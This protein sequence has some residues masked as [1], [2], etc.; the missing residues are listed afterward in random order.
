MTNGAHPIR[1]RPDIDGLRALAVVA[2]VLFHAGVPG[3]R[4]GF[5][6]VDVFFVISGFLITS[7]LLND[8]SIVGFYQRRARRILPALFALLAV[9]IPIGLL[10]LLPNDLNRLSRSIIATVSFVSNMYFWRQSD[11][12]AIATELWPMLHTW[13][14]GVEEQ[15]YIL[16][17]FLIRFSGNLSKRSLA[18]I[19]ALAGFCSF[20]ASVIGMENVKTTLVFYLAPTRAWELLVGSILATGVLPTPRTRFVGEVAALTGLAGILLPTFLYTA[21]TPFPGVGALAPVLGTAAVIWAGSKGPN[22]ASRL[23]SV[24]PVIFL[25][26]ISYSL[27]LWHWPV[28]AFMRYYYVVPLGPW[29]TS[30]ALLI[31]FVAAVISWRYVERPF[32]R[33]SVA[34]KAIWVF[35][36][37]GIVFFGGVSFFILRSGGLPGRVPPSLVALNEGSGD[38]WRCPLTTFVRF[39]GFYACPINLPNADPQ[40]ADV[41][42]WGDSHAQMYVPAVAR[43]RVLLVNANGCAP[44]STDAITPECGRIQRMNYQ[45]I[46]SSKP[47]I[48]VLAQNWPQYRDEAGVRLG[49]APLPSERYQDALRRLRRLVADLKEHGKSVYVVS[50]L[51]VPGY[52]VAS[53]V[54]RLRYFNRPMAKPLYI[55]ASDY[56]NEVAN[57]TGVLDELQKSGKIRIIR[58]DDALCSSGQCPYIVDHHAVYG[59]YSHF[60]TDSASKLRPVFDATLPRSE[61]ASTSAN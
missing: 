47:K 28:L 34:N 29:R 1:Y 23:I 37:A 2:V 10:L 30:M 36:L 9:V 17:P 46:I 49:R 7:I 19:F 27:Y 58:V 32:R 16:F 3:I 52:D 44:V 21:H 53:T 14:L 15:F 4:G 60:T 45:T 8:R 6:G 61:S 24:K 43:R 18:I 12:F 40:K 55:S 50:P 51:P 33:R 26:L 20:A 48:V 11:Y 57:I 31:S 41:I 38:T 13:S 25:G 39:G 54:S 42:L 22:M 5:V 35:S 59:D 56:R